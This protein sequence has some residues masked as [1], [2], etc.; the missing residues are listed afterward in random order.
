MPDMPW[1]GADASTNPEKPF[2]G[3]QS[4]QG[5]AGEED[6]MTWTQELL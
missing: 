5:T 6:G 4:E 1:N 2:E 3:V